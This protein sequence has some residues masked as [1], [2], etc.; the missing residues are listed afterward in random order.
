MS[1]RPLPLLNHRYWLKAAS[2]TKTGKLHYRFEDMD[3]EAMRARILVR[4]ALLRSFWPHMAHGV[5]STRPFTHGSTDSSASLQTLFLQHS[6]LW[7]MLDLTEKDVSYAVDGALVKV[8]K[9]D[10]NGQQTHD[11]LRACAHVGALNNVRWISISHP[12]D[13]AAAQFTLLARRWNTLLRGLP[14]TRHG[15]LASA[16]RMAR[17]AK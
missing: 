6:G 15:T 17:H 16:C 2:H 5:L 7:H 1:S 13:F 12:A 14:R 4:K 8:R 10:A 9:T 11:F 3:D